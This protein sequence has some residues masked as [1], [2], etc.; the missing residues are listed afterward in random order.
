MWRL[1]VEFGSTFLFFGGFV[2]ALDALLPVA[3]LHLFV[4]VISGRAH[5]ME[6]IVKH[7]VQ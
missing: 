5:V 2:L 6:E 1:Q 3:F 7:I 4:G